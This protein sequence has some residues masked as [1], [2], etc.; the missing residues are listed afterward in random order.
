MPASIQ[1]IGYQINTG[2]DFTSGPPKYRGMA[3]VRSDIILRTNVLKDAIR[4]AAESPS[5]DGAAVKIFMAPEFFFRDATGA[6]PV[7]SVSDV[8]ERMRAYTSRPQFRNWIFVLGTALGYLKADAGVEVFNIAL[9]Q[10]GGTESADA[11]DC[12]LVYK[13]YISHVDFIRQF[14]TALCECCNPPQPLRCSHSGN[15]A[16]KPWTDQLARQAQIAGG[17]NPLVPTQGSRDLNSA[18][19]S[20]GSE[21][22]VS[23]LGGQ[24]LFSM[25]GITFGLEVCLD[26]AMGRLRGAPSRGAQ[27]QVHLIPSAGMTI[28]DDRVVCMKDGLIFNVDPAQA[29]LR[30]NTGT[31]AAPRTTPVAAL[32]TH[33][34]PR[35]SPWTHVF[36]SDGQVLVYPTQ[37]V[38]D[39]PIVL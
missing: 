24:G 39:P 36:Q 35:K 26:H 9:V 28:L 5:L 16:A 13:E 33:A 19:K 2:T 38:P 20:T 3:D 7:E 6:Y 17:V 15:I 12:L 18:R 22:S 8:P 4:V 10:R 21:N 37:R 30:T 32:S 14:F 29:D 25:A 31:F 1:C 27:V 23:G 34:H 11:A